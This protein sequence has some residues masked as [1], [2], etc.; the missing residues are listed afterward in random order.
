MES[1]DTE[2]FDPARNMARFYVLSIEPTLFGDEALVRRWGR[3]GSYGRQRSEFF[4]EPA[5]AQVALEAWRIRKRR[6][7]YVAMS[8]AEGGERDRHARV[9]ATEVQ[10]GP[11][12]SR[13]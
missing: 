4:R 8:Q 2:R 7:G 9:A 1:G 5:A 13:R 11:G 3:I 12:R 10:A 6:R